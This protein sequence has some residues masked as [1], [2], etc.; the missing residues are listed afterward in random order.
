MTRRE[1]ERESLV[2][3]DSSTGSMKAVE[4]ACREA[5]ER[6]KHSD[7]SQ[8]ENMPSPNTFSVNPSLT[9]RSTMLLSTSLSVNCSAAVAPLIDLI[10]TAVEIVRGSTRGNSL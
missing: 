6:S 9:S 8:A 7:F 10:S 5:S 4:E 2:H 3:A 1:T